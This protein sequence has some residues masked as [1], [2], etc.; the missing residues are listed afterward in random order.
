MCLMEFTHTEVQVQEEALF[1]ES[2]GKATRAM[3]RC[4]VFGLIMT[5]SC[6]ILSTDNNLFFIIRWGGLC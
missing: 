5:D 3:Y 2:P 4:L 1:C 6:N